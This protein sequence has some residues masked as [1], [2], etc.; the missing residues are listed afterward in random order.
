MAKRRS[1][2]RAHSARRVRWNRSILPVVVGEYGA[3]RMWR[4][5][6]SVHIRSNST[7]PTPGPKR[8]VNTLPLS[9][10][11]WRGT[12]WVRNAHPNASHTGRA[13]ARATKAGADTE[14]AVV[15]DTG[16]RRQLGAVHEEDPPDD[17]QSAT[18]PST[19][20]RS[21]RR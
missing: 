15:I 5:P 12:P 7:G 6:L 16:D 11:N 13:V 10:S 14:P 21:Q 4:I 20:L 1:L 2:G 9:V 18:A 8:A 17:V 3:V 19:G